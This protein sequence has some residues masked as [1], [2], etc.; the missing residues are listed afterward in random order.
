MSIPQTSAYHPLLMQL[1]RSM[2]QHLDGLLCN[3][4]D[5]D[6]SV[7]A[8]DTIQVKDSEAD[9]FSGKRDHIL[10]GR[11]LKHQQGC[12]DACG[13]GFLHFSYASDSSRVGNLGILNGIGV[14]PNNVAFSLPPQAQIVDDVWKCMPMHARGRQTGRK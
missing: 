11:L 13:E 10:E 12:K 9:G 3:S 6:P 14:L 4:L 5:E 7:T 8:Q 2:G 1:Y